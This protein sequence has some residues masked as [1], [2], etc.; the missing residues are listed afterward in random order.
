[1][2]CYAVTG[3]MLQFSEGV[4]HANRAESNIS[5]LRTAFAH[6]ECSDNADD[7]ESDDLNKHVGSGISFGEAVPIPI[8]DVG[9]YGG[10]NSGEEDEAEATEE[11]FDPRLGEK[12]DD[13]NG[14]DNFSDELDSE[15]FTE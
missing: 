13:D 1:M 10:Q 14:F 15:Q 9:G 12:E 2:I 11:T 8:R 4:A 3:F 7:E 6:G 5:G